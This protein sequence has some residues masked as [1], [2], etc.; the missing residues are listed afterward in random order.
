LKQNLKRIR[1]RF[2]SFARVGSNARVRAGSALAFK[3]VRAR[4]RVANRASTRQR[5]ERI[6]RAAICR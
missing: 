4:P 1:V 2:R 3:R 6:A 5:V